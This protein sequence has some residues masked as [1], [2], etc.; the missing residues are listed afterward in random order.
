MG[1][2]KRLGFALFSLLPLGVA[3]TASAVSAPDPACIATPAAAAAQPDARRAWSA[4]QRWRYRSDEE[5]DTAY[6][7]LLGCE[8]PWPE[9]H[10]VNVVTLPRGLRFQMALAPG[11]PADRPGAFGTFDPIPDVEFVRRS[12]AV[13]QAWKRAI[14]RVVTY[15]VVAP[16][17]ADVGTVGPQIDAETGRYLP[18]GG[19]QLQMTVPAA[20]RM[21][22]LQV[23]GERPIQ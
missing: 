8:S 5:A 18:G 12:L 16:L 15:E 6:R 22:H 1:V 11:Q 20:E 21:Q 3:V 10:Q 23:V 7:T 4:D 9:W 19:S 2:W 17:S 14:D 13:K